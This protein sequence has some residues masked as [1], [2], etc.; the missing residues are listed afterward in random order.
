MPTPKQ[1][2]LI[3]LLRE[4]MGNL[5]ST[6]TLGGLLLKAGYTKATAKNAYLI[7]E[8][9]AIRKVTDNIADMLADKRK[10]AITHITERK[11]KDAPARELAYVAD[12]FTKNIQLITGRSTDNVAVSVQISEAIARKYMT[13]EEL[14]SAGLIKS[15]GGGHVLS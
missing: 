12:V 8:S 3:K 6:A 9:K 13:E 4:N 10:M 2:K 5:D 7:F 11:L 15:E 14:S 1:N